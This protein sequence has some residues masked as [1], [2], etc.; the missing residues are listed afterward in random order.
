VEFGF[1]EPSNVVAFYVVGQ[2][3]LPDQF[4]DAV[5]P[6]L[7]GQPP[8]GIQAARVARHDGARKMKILLGNGAQRIRG[9][10]FHVFK[11]GLETRAGFLRD[12]NGPPTAAAVARGFDQVQYAL[13]TV[14][15]RNAS[16]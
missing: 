5:R 3:R 12:D 13:R 6:I 9:R 16:E 8:E 7:H 1:R 2:T 11:N 4:D 15:E 10:H 14:N